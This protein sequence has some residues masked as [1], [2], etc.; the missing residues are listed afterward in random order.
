VGALVSG[1][2]DLV[3]INIWRNEYYLAHLSLQVY[4]Y[5]SREY[6]SKKVQKDCTNISRV[7][8]LVPPLLSDSSLCV[9]CPNPKS[10]K[11]HSG[12]HSRPKSLWPHH[13]KII[14][15]QPND[16]RGPNNERMIINWSGLDVRAT[17]R[18]HS[19]KTSAAVIRPQHYAAILTA[20]CQITG[21][22]PLGRGYSNVESLPS[23]S[24][25]SKGRKN[26]CK[27]V[28]DCCVTAKKKPLS[29]D[30]TGN[31]EDLL[32]WKLRPFTLRRH[33]HARTLLTGI[34]ATGT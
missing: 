34:A 30:E 7:I 17:S 10:G 31:K 8:A 28:A 23:G 6:F 1:I 2:G 4:P 3:L 29:S 18:P 33:H 26:V 24:T 5:L 21:V 12:I 25:T 20:T 11:N 13:T 27:N 9:I 19:Q 32:L 16:K 15:S 14:Y 22:L